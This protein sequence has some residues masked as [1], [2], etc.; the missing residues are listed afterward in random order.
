VGGLGFGFS[1]FVDATPEQVWDG[2]TDTENTEEIWFGRRVECLW[3]V[4]A[5][6]QFWRQAADRIAFIGKIIRC[7]RP[8]LLQFTWCFEG[9]EQA[10]R[11]PV[12]RVTFEISQDEGGR[13]T[14][15]KVTHDGFIARSRV[16]LSASRDWPVMIEKMK[17]FIEHRRAN[18]IPE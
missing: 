17:A 9:N 6:I 15:L 10:S 8:N 16:L 5:P 7:E 3:E 14:K 13:V 2:L 11:E 18:L 4:G 12:S 1:V